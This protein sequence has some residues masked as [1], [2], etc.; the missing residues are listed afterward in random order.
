MGGRLGNGITPRMPKVIDLPSDMQLRSPEFWE[1]VHGKVNEALNAIL[2]LDPMLKRAAEEPKSAAMASDGGKMDALGKVAY[3][4]LKLLREG[5]ENA[6]DASQRY[7]DSNA[8]G[9]R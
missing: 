1:A 7:V 4:S 8:V 5:V 9:A 2:V 6:R 3:D